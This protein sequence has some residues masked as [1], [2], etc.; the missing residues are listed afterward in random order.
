MQTVNFPEVLEGGGL[1]YLEAF[2]PKQELRV[3]NLMGFLC[4]Q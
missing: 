1:A 2:S 3:K 4:E